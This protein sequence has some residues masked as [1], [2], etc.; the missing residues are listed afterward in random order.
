MLQ[1][2]IFIR[3][4]KITLNFGH[5]DHRHISEKTHLI[6]QSFLVLISL[7][8]FTVLAPIAYYCAGPLEEGSISYLGYSQSFA[9]FISVAV[10][11]GISIVS[12]PDLADTYA[13][14]SGEEVL[15]KFEQRLRFVLLIAMFAVGAFITLKIP[16]ITL[17]YQRSSFS[18]ES[19]VKMASVLQWYLLAAVFTAALNLLRTLFYS[20]GEL[21]FIAILGITTPI[22]FFG[23]AWVMKNNF[24]FEGIGIAN[25]ITF[26]VLFIASVVLLKK[27]TVRFLANEFLLFIVS[28]ICI[29]IISGF[30]TT[31]CLNAT[32]QIDNQIILIGINGLIF[33]TVYLLCAKFVFRL[34]EVN[35]KD[36]FFVKIKN[37]S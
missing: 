7:L 19:V 9:G 35:K 4:S 33:F 32:A 2:I 8:P 29:T 13:A 18:P 12:F 36:L 30:I 15:L 24:S 25:A 17:F 27:N 1:F 16:I 26:S 6:N 23:L 21:R 14:G 5:F 10:G 28:S 3:A 34:K 20:R 22:L 37:L 31:L 11:M